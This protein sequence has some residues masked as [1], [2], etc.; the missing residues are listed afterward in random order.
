M[1]KN[2]EIKSAA[3]MLKAGSPKT[4]ADD[5]WKVGANALREAIEANVAG[6]HVKVKG[7]ERCSYEEASFRVSMETSIRARCGLWVSGEVSMK[8]EREHYEDATKLRA[9]IQEISDAFG[10]VELQHYQD[11]NGFTLPDAARQAVAEQIERARMALI[12]E[13]FERKT[14]E[15]LVALP[16]GTF[17]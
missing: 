6:P 8:I 10:D 14:A 15:A 4:E 1:K 13:G 5:T 2:R 12:R 16:F 7:F 3:D 17:E 11:M 9:R